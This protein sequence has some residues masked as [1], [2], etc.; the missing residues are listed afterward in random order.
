METPKDNLPQNPPFGNSL[1]EQYKELVAAFKDLQKDYE[2]IGFRNNAIYARSCHA[3]DWADKN[4]TRML[5]I[6]KGGENADDWAKHLG[7]EN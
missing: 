7:N 6:I 4:H 3:L 2:A 5:A 1:A